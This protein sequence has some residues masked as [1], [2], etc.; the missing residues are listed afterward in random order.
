MMIDAFSQTDWRRFVTFARTRHR[1]AF[2]SSFLQA[3]GSFNFVCRGTIEGTSCPNN[4]VANDILE[5]QNLE[6]EAV[7]RN[8]QA[9]DQIKLVYPKHYFFN[10]I[11]LCPVYPKH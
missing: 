3:E 4:A 6:P 10:L 1:K 7:R 9:L 11:K 5:L 8:L 2:I